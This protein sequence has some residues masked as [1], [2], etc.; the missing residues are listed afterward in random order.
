MRT[1]LEARPSAKDTILLG[2]LAIGV[3]DFFD[4]SLY[5]GLYSGA[6]FQRVWQGVASGLLGT[7]AATAGGWN[8]ALLG[9]GLH[10]GRLRRVTI[11]AT[12]D[13]DEVAAALDGAL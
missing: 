7:E 1:D 9:I 12:G 10:F 5:F 2:G 3:L 11:M 13:T 6:P 4:A 8:T